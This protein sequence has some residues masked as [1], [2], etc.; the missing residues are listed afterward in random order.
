MSAV[1]TVPRLRPVAVPAQRQRRQRA[2][3]EDL[4]ATVKDL[5]LQL[6]RRLDSADGPAARWRALDRDLSRLYTLLLI[7]RETGGQK[8]AGLCNAVD[9]LEL[10]VEGLAGRVERLEAELAAL[11][12]RQTGG[13]P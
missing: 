6:G 7:A 2:T 10:E 4:A 5:L 8:R 3:A 13:A 11:L 12:Q 1:P 9:A